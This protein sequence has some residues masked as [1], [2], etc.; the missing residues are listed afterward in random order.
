MAEED[1]VVMEKSNEGGM[2]GAMSEMRMVPTSMGQYEPDPLTRPSIVSPDLPEEWGGRPAGTSRRAIRM[3]EEWDKRQQSLIQ[4]QKEMQ[5][6]DIQ[7]KQFE[8]NVREQGLKEDDFYFNRGLKEAE[9]KLQSEQKAESRMF[10]EAMNDLNPQAENYRESMAK[11]RSEFPLASIDSRVEKIVEDYNKINEIFLN[12]IQQQREQQNAMEQEKQKIAK[13]AEQANLPMSNFITT[14]TKTGLDV[15]NYEALGRA[16]AIAAR[17]EPKV[18]EPL[19]GGQTKGEIQ[20][21][22]T[23]IGADIVEAE[24]A[25]D[26]LTVEKLQAKQKYYEDLLP[27]GDKG[28]ANTAQNQ[29][30]PA[31]K[32]EAGKVYPTPQ[33]DMKW[34]GTGWIKP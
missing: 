15:I 26:L 19:Y 23:T 9:Q 8:L 12:K 29:Y 3:Q 27:Q 24:K 10:I 2:R 30:I 20:K 31:D 6:M 33:G 5:Q 14:D 11:L 34:T 7:R 13:I 22:I 28:V 4:Q 21:I 32:R 17:K 16:E 25:N 1:V 18:E